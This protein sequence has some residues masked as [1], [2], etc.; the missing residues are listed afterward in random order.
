MI[1]E[2]D[3]NPTSDFTR[4]PNQLLQDHRL[5]VHEQILW[6][7]LLSLTKGDC[8]VAESACHAAS[9]C[10]L[11][12]D[13]FRD[14]RRNL[15]L[16]GYLKNEGRKIWVTLPDEKTSQAPKPQTSEPQAEVTIALEVEKEARRKPSGITEKEAHSIISESWNKHKPDGYATIPSTMNPATFI[17]IETQAKRLNYERPNYGKFVKR[18]LKGCNEDPWW[19]ERM[20][21]KPSN[22]FGFGNKPED[23]KFQN[24]EKLYK[25]GSKVVD[26]FSWRNEE[27]ILAWYNEACPDRTFNEVVHLDVPDAPASW[28]HDVEHQNGTTIFIYHSLEDD[29]FVVNWTLGKKIHALKTPPNRR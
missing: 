18:V 19:K 24:V 23:K 15:V 3:L 22:L 6:I 11:G 29:G 12:I 25:I 8:F 14:R 10:G 4:V 7:R 16:K 5:T 9:L 17:A 21:L 26:K 27:S 28:A 2:T 1:V 20:G 13:V